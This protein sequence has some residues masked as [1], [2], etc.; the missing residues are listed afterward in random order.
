MLRNDKIEGQKAKKSSRIIV[1]TAIY[2]N[3]RKQFVCSFPQT[4]HVAYAYQSI[5]I[6]FYCY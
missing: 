1:I 6:H 2:F 5:I 4:K 3:L